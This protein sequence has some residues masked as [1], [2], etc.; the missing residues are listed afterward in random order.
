MLHVCS[1]Y[2]AAISD[3]RKPAKDKPRHIYLKHMQNVS[4]FDHPLSPFCN[5]GKWQ[6]AFVCLF[7]VF[8][9]HCIGVERGKM[10][11]NYTVSTIMTR[12]VACLLVRVTLPQVNHSKE[13]L[14][15]KDLYHSKCMY[16]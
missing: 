2:S 3:P 8:C 6:T 9:Q 10:C 1:E 7:K 5:V 12:L 11:G 15:K 14:Q 13:S 16:R 4:N